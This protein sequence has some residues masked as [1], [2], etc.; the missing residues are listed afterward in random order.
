MPLLMSLQSVISTNFFLLF[1]IDHPTSAPLVGSREVKSRF[2][3]ECLYI[4]P[5]LRAGVFWR[6]VMGLFGGE[7][8]PFDTKSVL[9]DILYE[10]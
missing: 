4:C 1:F 3:F 7:G 10:F 8:H 5:I 6:I 9:N 2:L